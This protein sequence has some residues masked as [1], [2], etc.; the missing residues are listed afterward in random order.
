MLT[1]SA[2]A[3]V[4][5]AS[6]AIDASAPNSDRRRRLGRKVH[7]VQVVITF[8]AHLSRWLSKQ[9]LRDH[10]RQGV[11]V[12]GVKL[13]NPVRPRYRV[14]NPHT[15][16]NAIIGD[17][18]V[19]ASSSVKDIVHLKRLVDLAEPL[20]PVRRAT[21]A[22]FVERQLEPT[23]QIFHLLPYRRMAR[24]R[25]SADHYVVEIIKRGQSLREKLAIRRALNETVDC[26]KA[27]LRRQFAQA[28]S[29]EMLVA[30]SQHRETVS[31]HD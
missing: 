7:S 16:S 6:S 15:A 19:R 17:Q 29:D 23:Q 4:A 18:P 3:G 30:G 5:A 24:I 10:D 14:K 12:D 13:V 20:D 27:Q 8:M 31:H 26:A 1:S 22:A 28:L 11:Q 2:A 25:A 9:L 21:P